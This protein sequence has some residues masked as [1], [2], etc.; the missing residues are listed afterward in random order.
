MLGYK[1]HFGGIMESIDKDGAFEDENFCLQDNQINDIILT[2]NPDNLEEIENMLKSFKLDGME[3]IKSLLS[4]KSFRKLSLFIHFLVI[5]NEAKKYILTVDTKEIIK[6]LLGYLG[7]NREYNETLIYEKCKELSLIEHEQDLKNLFPK[8][9]LL[10][11]QEKQVNRMILNQ[12]FEY[13]ANFS[14][15]NFETNL[16]NLDESETKYYLMDSVKIKNISY[17]CKLYSSIIK[18][19]FDNFSKID[20]YFKIKIHD[21]FSVT[22]KKKNI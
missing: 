1:L 17:F 5:K 15:L 6:D 19:I 11:L 16:D 12:M 13:G 22:V 14:N 9:Y 20:D 8:L 3:Y 2:E 10:F 18:E 21:L 4:H 7:I